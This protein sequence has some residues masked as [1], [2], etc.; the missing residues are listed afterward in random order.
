MRKALQILAAVLLAVSCRERDAGRVPPPV[1]VPPP[2]VQPELLK[3]KLLDGEGV[4]SLSDFRG[5]IVLVNFFGAAKDECRAEIGELNTL[6]NDLR[7]RP[8]QLIG[9]TFDLKPQIY[10]KEDLRSS[11]PTFPCALG[12]KPARQAF[13]SVRVLP[14]KW[15]LDREGKIVKRYEGAASFTQIRADISELLK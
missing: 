5:K 15:L 14:T 9:I 7:D 10:V 8:F 12:E 2:T 3:M 6:A 11:M 4:V 1:L 13:P